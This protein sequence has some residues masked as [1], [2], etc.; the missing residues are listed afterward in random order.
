M[1]LS[2]KVCSSTIKICQRLPPKPHLSWSH[3][4][5]LLTQLSVSM[6]ISHSQRWLRFKIPNMHCIYMIKLA[7]NGKRILTFW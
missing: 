1:D 3:S 4:H 2:C 7:S 5:L 6:F